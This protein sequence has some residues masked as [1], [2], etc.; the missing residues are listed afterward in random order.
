MVSWALVASSSGLEQAAS[1]NEVATAIVTVENI[2]RF[3][4]FT[5]MKMNST[6]KKTYLIYLI[7]VVS[8]GVRTESV[9][10]SASCTGS[11]QSRMAVLS[12]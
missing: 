8:F 2:R 7:N 11:S 10:T 12:R 9:A 5:V 1:A 3:I 6:C 4:E